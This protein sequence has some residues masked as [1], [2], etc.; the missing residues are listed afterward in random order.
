MMLTHDKNDGE[1]TDLLHLEKYLGSSTNVAL[2]TPD[3][4]IAID[5]TLYPT[6]SG[7]SFKTC[8]KINQLN[9]V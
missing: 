7:I 8:I 2:K 5:E 3:D 4:Y 6:R 1:Q 9:M